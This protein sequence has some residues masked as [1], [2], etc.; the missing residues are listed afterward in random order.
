MA[1]ETKDALQVTLDVS[2]RSDDERAALPAAIAS[3]LEGFLKSRFPTD[4]GFRH[5]RGTSQPF[6]E[7][8]K[9]L[10][11][12]LAVTKGV[13]RGHAVEVCPGDFQVG[14]ITVTLK[15]HRE[16]TG[17]LAL[18]A[19]LAGLAA[20]A[21][22]VALAIFEN[23]DPREPWWHGDAIPVIVA[24]TFGGGAAVF[25]LLWL[26][27]R[28]AVRMLTDPAREERERQ[29]LWQELLPHLANV[30]EP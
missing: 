7:W 8:P 5:G 15:T 17:L 6:E 23:R 21:G 19:I 22:A 4:R 2:D 1:S 27:S 29:A 28:P 16:L 12:W 13:L 30:Q 18:L 14:R 9:L 25:G 10:S 11:H 26:L 3:R 20:G 24:A